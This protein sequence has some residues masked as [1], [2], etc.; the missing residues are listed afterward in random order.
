MTRDVIKRLARYA[1][2]D[3]EVRRIALNM[4][5]VRQY[6]P[7]PN[8]VKESDARTPAYRAQFGT[9]D[10]WELDALSPTVIADLIL[11]RDSPQSACRRRT[12][13]FATSC[14]S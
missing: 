3:I 4:P 13:G 10:C 5:Q 12:A 6:A 14:R 7:P 8:F 1:R 2:A 9:D 11:G